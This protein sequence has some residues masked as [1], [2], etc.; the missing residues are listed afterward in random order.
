M[1]ELTATIRCAKRC[2]RALLNSSGFNLP[3]TKVR[4]RRR[5]RGGGVPDRAEA[6]PPPRQGQSSPDTRRRH[7]PQ[8]S[9]HIKNN[10]SNDCN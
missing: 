8:E 2:E 4:R 7:R 5:G 1:I 6:T 10:G 9:Q 3:P